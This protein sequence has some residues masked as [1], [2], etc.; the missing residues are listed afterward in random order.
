MP[1]IELRT[2]WLAQF[3]ALLVRFIWQLLIGLHGDPLVWRLTVEAKRT[4]R[5]RLGPLERVVRHASTVEPTR[6]REMPGFGVEC[7]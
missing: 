7:G 3:Q 2:K 4:R 5:W 6:A 1:K